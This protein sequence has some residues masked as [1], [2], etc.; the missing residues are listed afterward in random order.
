[1]KKFRKFVYIAVMALCCAACG[2]DEG[3]GPDGP[4]QPGT[5]GVEYHPNEDTFYPMH[6]MFNE[7]GAYISEY[8]GNKLTVENGRVTKIT[9]NS[10]Y[11]T[12]EYN[13]PDVT[14]RSYST[15]R[16]TPDE[17]Y[18]IRLNKQGFAERVV[19]TGSDGVVRSYDIKYDADGHMTE[20]VQHFEADGSYDEV[21]KLTWTNGNVTKV[22]CEWPGG[23]SE[24]TIHYLDRANSCGFMLYDAQLWTDTDDWGEILYCCGMLGRATANFVD[25]STCTEVDGGT[26]RFKLE[27]NY[28]LDSEGRPS[29]VTVREYEIYED[30]T[31]NVDNMELDF[32][33]TTRP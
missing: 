7:Y 22:N 30:N 8:D 14:M 13:Y 25:Y 6:E 23:N 29:K 24:A 31:A 21:A 28:I 16:A 20:F 26:Y 1:M 3:D 2:D 5:G 18:G 15:S 27:N 12:L 4:D 33:W 19:R 32:F 11:A 10:G 9:G 17:T